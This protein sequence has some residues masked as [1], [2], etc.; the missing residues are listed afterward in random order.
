MKWISVTDPAGGTVWINAEQVIRVRAPDTPTAH[1]RC[2]LDLA[3]GIQTVRESI[4]DI[5]RLMH[6]D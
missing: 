1:E 4:D 5:M 6:R 3:N 2:T